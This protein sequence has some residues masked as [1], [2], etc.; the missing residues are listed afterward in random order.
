[1]SFR[2]PWLHHSQGKI[3]PLAMSKI[4][5]FGFGLDFVLMKVYLT[6][7]KADKVCVCGHRTDSKNGRFFVFHFRC[8]PSVH[9]VL[10][11]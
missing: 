8:R 11:G 5:F 6:Q 1:M 10:L 9:L 2:R 7:E 4:D 3:C